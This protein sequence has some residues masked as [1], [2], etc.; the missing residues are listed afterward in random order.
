MGGAFGRLKLL[1]VSDNR[2]MMRD[3]E[4]RLHNSELGRNN[5]CVKVRSRNILETGQ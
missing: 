3:A 5:S 2:L 1:V 4:S